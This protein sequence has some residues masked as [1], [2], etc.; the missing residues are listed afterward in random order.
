MV[1]H[2][3]RPVGRELVDL[4]Q[5][6]ANGMFHSPRYPAPAITKLSSI[7]T[8]GMSITHA[9]FHAHTGTHVD[10]P[11]HFIPGSESITEISLDRFVGEG[12]VVSVHR[13]AREEIPATDVVPQVEAFGPDAMVCLHSGW[14]TKYATAAEYAQYP[15]LSLDLAHALV[16]LQVRMLA[17][18]TPSPDMPNGPRPPYFNWPVHRVLMEGGVLITEQ[19]TRLDLIRGR[20]FR[21]HAL[22]I[23]LARSDGAPARVVAEL[24]GADHLVAP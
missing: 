24:R 9:S 11:S 6:I 20:R 17:L 16:E 2:D 19:V 5:P 15:F 21:L 13:R 22:P 18:D 12:I 8:D 14:D 23:A 7:D 4:S 1:N 10:A 3:A